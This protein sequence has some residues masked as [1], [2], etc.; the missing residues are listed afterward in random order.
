M[1]DVVRV[2][3]KQDEK[4]IKVFDNFLDHNDRDSLENGLFD[5]TFPWYYNKHTV[6]PDN[7]YFKSDNKNLYD[8]E[9]LVHGFT[10]YQKI[11]STY[12]YLPLLVWNKFV[13]TTQRTDY[14]VLRMKANLAFLNNK[15]SKDTYSIP[16]IDLDEEHQTLI[17]YVNYCDGD[18]YLF[19]KDDPD[20]V[21]RRIET[22][23]GRL[24]WLKEPILHSAGHPN[25]FDKR[26]SVVIN[27]K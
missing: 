9:Q 12:T 20:N 1:N 24:I 19:Q 22:R 5:E 16:H 26:C 7:K 13:N 17:Y 21:K 6:Y 27:F 8:N 14:Q 15:M 23:R 3:K 11:N 2:A 10:M 18:L 4:A 25:L